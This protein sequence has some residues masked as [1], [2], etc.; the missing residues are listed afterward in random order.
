MV[1]HFTRHASEILIKYKQERSSQKCKLQEY[2]REKY[3]LQLT[4]FTVKKTRL[5]NIWQ[6]RKIL[7]LF[8]DHNLHKMGCTKGSFVW[9][10]YNSKDFLLYMTTRGTTTSNIMFYVWIQIKG[11]PC[12]GTS[13]RNMDF[14]LSFKRFKEVHY[15]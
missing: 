10:H 4:P 7:D 5:Q 12:Q 3:L 11:A 14:L 13:H 8:L 6:N 9:N 15:L 2:W 1:I